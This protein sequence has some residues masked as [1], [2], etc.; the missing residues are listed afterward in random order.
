MS[1][2][3]HPDEEARLDALYRYNILDT[4][5]EQAFDDITQLVAAICNAPIS[6]VNLIDRDRQ[7][8]KSEVGLGVRE[9][10][11]DI[12]LCAHAI[13]QP[14]LFVVADTLQDERFAH[15]PLVTGEPHLRFYAGV[16]LESSDGLPLGTLCVLD[17][18]PRELTE[19]QKNALR[20]LGRQVMSLLELRRTLQQKAVTLLESEDHYRY[21]VELNPQFPWIADPDGSIIDFN[22]RWL[23]FT[24]LTRPQALGGGW[25]QIPHPDDLPQMQAA[26]MHAVQ[27]GA[28]YDVEHRIKLADGTYRW[29]RSRALP[30]RDEAGQII[31]WYGATEDIEER[32]LSELAREALVGKQRQFLRE[33][34]LGFTEGK[35]RLCDS[36]QDLPTPLTPSSE[37][38]EL[39]PRALRVIRRCAQVVAEELHLPEDRWQDLETGVG[40]AA[41]NAVRHGLEGRGRVYADADTGSIQVWV[42]D[43]GPG[44]AE[45]LIHRAVERH[46]TTGGFGQ[47]FWL[48]LKTCDRVYLLTGPNG[49]TVVLEQEHQE[50]KP[51]WL[52]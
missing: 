2:P 19:T 37:I 44:I 48:M 51:A 14:G 10:P 8:F 41:M 23:D 13:L 40:E 36:E 47:G 26:W 1:P 31:R 22:Q 34:L 9:T 46:W 50:P 21:S 27:T 7:W 11:L 15:N 16:Q 3:K 24:G 45:D 18:K 38:I 42:W 28:S 6:V 4:A 33:M 25:A 49:T 30:R 5:E 32:K 17:D 43:V 29:M 12:S 39:S 52:L 20:V 35:L